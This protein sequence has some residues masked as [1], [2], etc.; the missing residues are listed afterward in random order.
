MVYMQGKGRYNAMRTNQT[1]H[2]GIM[3]GLRPYVGTG[4][5]IANRANSRQRIPPGAIPGLR[6][7]QEHDILSVNPA[8]SGGVGRMQLLI[9]RAM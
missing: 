5:V 8:G 6:Y 9:S 7:M 3:G 2:Y 4:N 1:S